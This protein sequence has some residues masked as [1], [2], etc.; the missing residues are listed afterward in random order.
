MKFDKIT[1]LTDDDGKHLCT[2]EGSTL[3]FGLITIA[4][5]G[6]S[7]ARTLLTA[8]AHR[9]SASEGDEGV[10]PAACP[11]NAFAN[12]LIVAASR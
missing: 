12:S 1:C 4:L 11:P 9:Q 10:L 2:T 8:G 5:V 7:A 3:P 6:A